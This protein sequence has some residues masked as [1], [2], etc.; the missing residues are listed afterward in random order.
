MSR[1]REVKGWG[2]IAGFT[3]NRVRAEE[4]RE[5]FVAKATASG[6]EKDGGRK[7]LTEPG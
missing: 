3:G 7:E 6:S 4:T 2:D 5:G 1:P